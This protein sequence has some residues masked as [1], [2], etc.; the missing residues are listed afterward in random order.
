MTVTRRELAQR[1]KNGKTTLA[2]HGREHYV[3]MGKLGSFT[4]FDRVEKANR[5]EAE[6]LAR[7][8][9]ET[10]EDKRRRRQQREQSTEQS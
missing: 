10:L 2:R 7:I 9:C 6:R 1:T 5:E 4:F 3:R 8:K